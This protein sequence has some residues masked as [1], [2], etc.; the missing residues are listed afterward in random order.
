MK[1]RALWSETS[2]K[3]VFFKTI[4]GFSILDIYF[5]PFSKTEGTFIFKFVTENFGNILILSL[6]PYIVSKL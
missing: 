5:C 3:R 4:L 2:K 6:L 1:M